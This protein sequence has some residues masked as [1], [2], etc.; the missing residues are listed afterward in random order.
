MKRQVG[1]E[2]GE[3]KVDDN[4]GVSSQRKKTLTS[5]NTKTHS[6]LIII[7]KN[8]LPKFKMCKAIAMQNF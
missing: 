8:I 4:G 1:V 3:A 2:Q 7:K 6:K 5:N